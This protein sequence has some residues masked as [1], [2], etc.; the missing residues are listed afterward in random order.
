LAC[1]NC[2][3]S[4]PQ[5]EPR[6]FSFNSPFGACETCNGLGNTWSFDPAKIIVDPSKPL[7]DGGLGPGA[8]SSYMNHTLGEAAERLRIKLN[9]PFEDLPKKTQTLLLEGGNGFPGVVKILAE[10]YEEASAGYREWL[11][12]YMSPAVCPDCHG[13]R[14]RP[15]SLAVSVKGAGLA[16]LT[17]MSIDRALSTVK[18][19]VLQDR[20]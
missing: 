14:L 12:D 11:M 5:L 8:S 16:Q 9:K 6:S 15:S 1:P 10:T 7:L 20:E 19:W 4:V 17:E 18:T 3:A 2:G 13:R